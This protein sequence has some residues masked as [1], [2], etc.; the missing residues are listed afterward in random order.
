MASIHNSLEFFD[1]FE[2]FDGLTGLRDLGFDSF[3]GL[4]RLDGL[5][6]LHDLN[7]DG[8]AGLTDLGFDVLKGLSLS[9]LDGCGLIRFLTQFSI[10]HTAGSLDRDTVA[11]GHV[12]FGV[13]GAV[14]RGMRH[15]VGG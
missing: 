14:F 7:F 10:F 15:I 8:L 2:F 9:D 3:N 13:S 1:G 4:Y 5:T 6:G 11:V 12:T